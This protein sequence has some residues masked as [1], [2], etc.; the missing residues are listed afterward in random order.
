MSFVAAIGVQA[1][2]AGLRGVGRHLGSRSLTH[3]SSGDAFKTAPAMDSR[4]N[5]YVQRRSLLAALEPSRFGARVIG[6]FVKPDHPVRESDPA[7]FLHVDPV[8]H[9]AQRRE[10]VTAAAVAGLAGAGGMDRDAGEHGQRLGLAGVRL[11]RVVPATSMDVGVVP[12]ARGEPVMGAYGLVRLR[13]GVG[14]AAQDRAVDHLQLTTARLEVP[15]RAFQHG[16]R[17]EPF[18]QGVDAV[19]HVTH[20]V[21]P[22]LHQ[23]L[24]V[25]LPDLLVG[26]ARTAMTAH[27]GHQSSEGR[28]RDGAGDG[29]S[30]VSGDRI[31]DTVIEQIDQGEHRVPDPLFTKID[32]DDVVEQ[33]V[34]R[35]VG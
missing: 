35:D 4:R 8:R 2:E 1:N 10:R 13:F 33:Q 15:D 24:R 26:L 17:A 28:N 14:I 16:E 30:V 29:L 27:R 11:R 23:G 20:D 25:G 6:S 3:V 31:E 12:Q 7:A 5:G 18:T 32:R 22:E 21:L 34:A 9:V 19:A